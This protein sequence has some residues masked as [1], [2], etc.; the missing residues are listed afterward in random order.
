[1]LAR[2][3]R[4]SLLVAQQKSFIEQVP[5]KSLKQLPCLM[6]QRL[7]MKRKR[8][9][10]GQFA[11]MSESFVA[12]LS[13]ILRRLKYGFQLVLMLPFFYF[14]CMGGTGGCAGF[15]THLHTRVMKEKK[16][17]KKK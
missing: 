5:V 3:K 11:F 13:I 15:E 4:S 8:Q 12:N 10:F 1:M 14:D 17:K 2:K 6:Y 16:R 7:S 9:I